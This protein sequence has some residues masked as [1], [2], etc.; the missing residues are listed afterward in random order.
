MDKIGP[1][2]NS[3][4]VNGQRAAIA[5]WVIVAGLALDI[6]VLLLFSAD[7]TWIETAC[8][9]FATVVIAAGVGFEIHFDHK[10]AAAATELQQISDEKISENER[11]AAEANQKAS[12]AQL[13]LERIRRQLGPRII[14]EQEFSNALN[15]K[16]IASVEIL[17]I[18]DISDGFHLASQLSMLLKKAS[19]DVTAVKPLASPS[20][21]EF[22]YPSAFSAGGNP[23]GVTLVYSKEISERFLES[24][25]RA[26]QLALATT[27]GIVTARSNNELP[28]EMVRLVIGPKP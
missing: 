27:F 26:L 12:E 9:I 28:H 24:A 19:W 17:Y 2:K 14:L 5:A 22:P 1:L 8:A 7:K 10:A 13:E 4:L 20:D 18:R 3:F 6:V 25:A 16:P 11:L 15:G 21:A 23:S